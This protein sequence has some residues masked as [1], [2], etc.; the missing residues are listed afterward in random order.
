M[1]K[2][3]AM[4][5]CAALALSLASAA[6]ETRVLTMGT[7]GTKGTYFAF[8]AEIAQLWGKHIEGIEV[9]PQV[10]SA[11]KVNIMSIND[12]EAQLGFSQNDTI[13]YAYNGDKDQFEGEVVDSF[14]AIGALYPEAVQLVVAADSPFMSVQDLK[15]KRVSIGAPGSGTAINA[16][17]ILEL[18]GLTLD[19][20]EESWFSFAESATAMQ[21]RQ[22][23]AAF[24]T[25]GVPNPAI[26]EMAV[27]LPVRLIPL[28]ADD[29]AALQAKYPFYVPVTV[30]RD[31]YAGQA[32]DVTIAS[33]TAVIIAARDLEDDLVYQLTR[34]LFEK[35]GELIHAKARELDPVFAV[36]GVPCPIHPGAARYYKEINVEI[37]EAS[38]LPE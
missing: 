22:I 20:V 27:K 17:Q 29:M 9:S 32:E 25:G 7:G 19:D 35:S 36:S 10:T 18:A 30:P 3:L 8:G 11:S 6:A 15:G 14:Y 37:P 16:V 38:R 2:W 12:G 21:N 4:M 24:I 31:T 1:K 34:T 33:I 26:A 13:F 28:S 5:L 23:D